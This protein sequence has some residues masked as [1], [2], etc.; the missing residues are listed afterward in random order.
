METAVFL[1][2]ICYSVAMVG[3]TILFTIIWWKN[4]KEKK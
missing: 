3:G 4:R 2:W 1:A